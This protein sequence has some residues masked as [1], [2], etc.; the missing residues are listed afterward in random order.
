VGL[1]G[2]QEHR[3]VVGLVLGLE[4]AIVMGVKRAGELLRV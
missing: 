4:R 2:G 1:L 3:R